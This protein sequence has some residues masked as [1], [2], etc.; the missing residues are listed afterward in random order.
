MSVAIITKP[1]TNVYFCPTNPRF[2]NDWRFVKGINIGQYV[3]SYAMNRWWGSGDLEGD[4]PPP[5]RRRIGSVRRTA[6][7]IVWCDMVPTYVA[8]EPKGNGT[9]SFWDRT[10]S[11][12]AP[13]YGQRP[14]MIDLIDVHAGGGNFVMADGH[15]ERIAMHEWSD[16]EKNIYINNK[17]K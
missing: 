1:R 6:Q 17:E 11:W 13:G 15:V 4:A 3:T 14:Y 9:Y 10:P 8:G 7:L 5:P 2:F 16:Q 12:Q